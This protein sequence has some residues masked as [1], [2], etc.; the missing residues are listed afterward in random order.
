MNHNRRVVSFTLA[1]AGL[2]LLS[3]VL[4]EVT[5]RDFLRLHNVSL[6]ADVMPPWKGDSTA[7]TVAGAPGASDTAGAPAG[8]GPGNITPLRPPDAAAFA[9]YY[10]WPG[11][12]VQFAADSALPALPRFGAAVRELKAGKKR[13]LRIAWLGDSIIEG[14]Q[15]TKTVRRL[16]QQAYGGYGVGFV[17]ITSAVNHFRTTVQHS[18]TADGEWKD[19]EENFRSKETSTPLFL[20]GHIFRNS[21]AAVT[22]KDLTDRDSSHILVK[23]LLCGPVAAP[24]TIT[25]NGQ[26]RSIHPTALFNRIVLDSSA[27]KQITLGVA[28]ASLPLFGISMEPVSGVVLDNFSFRGITGVELAKI[29]PEMLQA[30]VAANDYDL[31][32]LEYGAN[33]LFR[34]NDVNQDWYAGKM[35]PIL[36]SLRNGMP[37]SDF[38][39]VSTG[40]R[41]FRYGDG[42]WQTAVGLDTLV[43]AQA[44]LAAGNG[45]SFFNLFATM[46]GRGTIVRWAE[47]ESPS[48]ANKDYIHPNA[49]GADWLAEAFFRAFVADEKKLKGNYATNQGN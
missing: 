19:R 15:M 34:P 45:Y 29:K 2:L 17:P 16:L 4:V 41:A 42:G 14:D 6:I 28:D 25:V 20:S 46:G 7:A 9:R 31:V 37:A 1:A 18:W 27:G 49:R 21:G 35:R 40:D 26:P 13:R 32:I 33:L 23:S 12:F 43:R 44:G 30:I 10:N 3:S 48:M 47:Q 39:L 22:M 5:G 11:L 38:L 8:T 36:R 24:V